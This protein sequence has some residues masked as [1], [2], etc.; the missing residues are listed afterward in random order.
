MMLTVY[1]EN[2]ISVVVTSWS[3]DRRLNYQWCSIYSSV[4]QT[5]AVRLH[6][7]ESVSKNTTSW[8]DALVF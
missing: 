7:V 2:S 6:A 3:C 4:R 5:S 1:F 8:S